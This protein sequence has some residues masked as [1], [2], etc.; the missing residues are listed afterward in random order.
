[1]LDVIQIEF[2]SFDLQRLFFIEITQFLEIRMAKHRVIVEGD[3][4]IESNQSIVFRQQEWIDLDQRGIH[5]FVS[6]VEGLHEFH[7]LRNQFVWQTQGES[8]FARL[9]RSK[10]DRRIYGLLKNLFRGFGGN[11]FDVHSARR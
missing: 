8:Q 3:L 7:C 4:G 5:R 6:D 2:R 9:K 1:E 11:L 10:A